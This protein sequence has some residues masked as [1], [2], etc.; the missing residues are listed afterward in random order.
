MLSSVCISDRSPSARRGHPARN[1]G[2]AAIII[3]LAVFATPVRAGRYF[4]QHLRSYDPT[5]SADSGGL[6]AFPILQFAI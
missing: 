5:I 3:T 4:W 2:P 1:R 6:A